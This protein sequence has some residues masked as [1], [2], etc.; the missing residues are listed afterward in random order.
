MDALSM[1]DDPEAKDRVTV[2]QAINEKGQ[3]ELKNK[4]GQV[5]MVNSGFCI[6]CGVCAYTCPSKSLVLVR[7]ETITHPP[8]DVREW[9]TQVATAFAAARSQAGEKGEQ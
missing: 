3:K 5:S 4:K 7:N 1:E 9:V 2:V 8:K 6:G